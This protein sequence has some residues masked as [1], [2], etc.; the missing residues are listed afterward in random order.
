MCLP[1]LTNTFLELYLLYNFFDIIIMT[2]DVENPP[3][4]VAKWQKNSWKQG[5]IRAH[6]RKSKEINVSI[7]WHIITTKLMQNKRENVKL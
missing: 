5:K 7:L 4:R 6:S 1:L 2:E 3:K